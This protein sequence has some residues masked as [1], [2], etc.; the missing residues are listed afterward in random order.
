MNNKQE[1]HI[2][3]S[4]MATMQN[5]HTAYRNT[6]EIMKT[7]QYCDRKQMQ[8]LYLLVDSAHKPGS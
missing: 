8:L 3:Y 4:G 7:P 6:T 2:W 1:G 5:S